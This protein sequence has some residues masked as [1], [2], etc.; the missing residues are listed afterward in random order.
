MRYFRLPAGTG[1]RDEPWMSTIVDLDTDLD[2]DLDTGR[3]LGVVDG[4]DNT[5]V[6][7]WLS[8]P[9]GVAGEDRGRRHRPV[10]G[11]PA[12]AATWR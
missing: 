7:T 2:L 8:A 12:A 11:E 1:R 10:M 5:G 6:R 3:V 4:H 9:R